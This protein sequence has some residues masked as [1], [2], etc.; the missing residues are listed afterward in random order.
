[1]YLVLNDISV[2]TSSDQFTI[3]GC[4]GIGLARIIRPSGVEEHI[5][6]KVSNEDPGIMNIWDPCSLS[7][8]ERRDYVVKLYTKNMRNSQIAAL[9]NV[10]QATICIDLKNTL[11][12]ENRNRMEIIPP[13]M[14]C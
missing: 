6:F 7:V 12:K 5:H 9:L 10:S 8:D 1:M 11:F 4:C 13:N 2:D 14:P 3:L